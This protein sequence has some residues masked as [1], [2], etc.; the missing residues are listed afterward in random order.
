[1]IV[2]NR[3]TPKAAEVGCWT[4]KSDLCSTISVTQTIS[5]TIM[6]WVTPKA[7]AKHNLLLNK[8]ASGLLNKSTCLTVTLGAVN[9]H[10]NNCHELGHTVVL[11]RYHLN[12]QESHLWH[13]IVAK[14]LIQVKWPKFSLTWLKWVFWKFQLLSEKEKNWMRMTIKI[15]EGWYW[16]QWPVL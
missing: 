11:L 13:F 9:F 8:L 15:S 3:V 10:N 6:N 5:V 12:V 7:G 4:S 14:Y 1:M 2:N 16:N